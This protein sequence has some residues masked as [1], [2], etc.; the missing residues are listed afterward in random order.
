MRRYFGILLLFSAV[1][2]SAADQLRQQIVPR[3]VTVGEPAELVLTVEG[4]KAP[5]FAKVPKVSGLEWLGSGSSVQT[6]IINGHYTGSAE[7]RYSFI[8]E[9]P[10]TYTIPA[11]AVKV[12]GRTVMSEPISFT[13][14]NATLSITS[15]G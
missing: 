1:L 8:V 9:K 4:K 10:G 14:E 13:A 5:I 3:P 12:N 2:C 6:R 11:A 15:G 7:R